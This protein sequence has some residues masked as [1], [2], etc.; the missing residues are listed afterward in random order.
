MEEFLANLNIKVP[1]P[2]EADGV[3]FVRVASNY[4]RVHASGYYPVVLR[5][6]PSC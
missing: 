2:Q 4:S 5:L 6:N 3:P 1:E